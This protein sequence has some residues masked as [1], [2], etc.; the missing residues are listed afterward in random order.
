M[1]IISSHSYDQDGFKGDYFAAAI[2]VCRPSAA[3]QDAGPPLAYVESISLQLSFEN[4]EAMDTL[5][6]DA[7]RAVV[8]SPHMHYLRI[9]YFQQRNKDFETAKRVLCSV[10]RRTQLTWA[11]ESGK[12]QFGRLTGDP[13]TSADILSVPAEHIIDGITTITLDIAEQADWLLYPVQRR[14]LA[15]DTTREEYLRQL[16]A[17]RASG[18]SAN[19]GSEVAPP[20]AGSTQH[21]ALEQTP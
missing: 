17:A 20:I 9:R 3:G 21:T 8:D 14:H 10:L 12:L 1:L 11:L 7:L 19:L 13:V 15:R 2:K 4:V 6:W 5:D 18:A 16:V